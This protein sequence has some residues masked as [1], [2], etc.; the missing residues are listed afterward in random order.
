MKQTNYDATEDMDRENSP[1][2]TRI[3]LQ[4]INN[5]AAPK[6]PSKKEKS[7]FQL[8]NNVT[9]NNWQHFQSMYSEG[10]V[11]SPR[12]LRGEL[13]NWRTNSFNEQ[14]Y[15]SDL[16]EPF[17]QASIWPSKSNAGKNNND[18]TTNFIDTKNMTGKSS[19]F[20]PD[21]EYETQYLS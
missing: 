4:K 20:K 18:E 15:Q 17:S 2:K 9:D 7:S 3:F 10:L 14:L 11:G 5:N 12:Q 16:N 21:E 6:V 8:L 1:S 19:V 13:N